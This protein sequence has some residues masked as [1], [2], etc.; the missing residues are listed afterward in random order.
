MKSLVAAVI[1][2]SMFVAGVLFFAPGMPNALVACMSLVGRS[3]ACVRQQEHANAT[4][5][6]LWTTPMLLILVAGYVAIAVIVLRRSRAGG[7]LNARLHGP[8]ARLRTWLLTGV[9][10]VLV[11]YAIAAATTWPRQA[12]LH[13]AIAFGPLFL[14]ILWPIALA[15]WWTGHNTTAQLVSMFATTWIAHGLG[16]I[17]RDLNDP[18]VA[19]EGL[20]LRQFEPAFLPALVQLLFVW[21]V[22]GSV[23]LVLVGSLPSPGATPKE[24]APV[25]STVPH[26]ASAH[27]GQP[28][29]GE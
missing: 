9:T 19:M 27:D 20:V 25:P 2:W 26:G 6:S 10:G 28:A 15:A 7:L 16:R 5:M 11:V 4:V 13:S 8:D 22:L 21:F 14:M 24:T 1:G 17:V 12:D 29:A 23:H 18:T 3:E